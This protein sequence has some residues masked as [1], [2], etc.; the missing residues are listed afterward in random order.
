MW[1][2]GHSPITTY[3]GASLCRRHP[4]G[5]SRQQSQPRGSLRCAERAM[6]TSW[7]APCSCGVPP[8]ALP[9]RVPRCGAARAP[10]VYRLVR[11]SHAV[12]LGGTVDADGLWAAPGRPT[13]HALGQAP[14][15]RPAQGS[16][17]GLWGVSH[18]LAVGDVGMR[19]PGHA[20]PCGLRWDGTVRASCIGLGVE[21]GHGGRQ[22]ERSAARRT[23]GPAPVAEGA[24]ASACA[25]GL[26]GC[27]RSPSCGP[28]SGPRGGPEGVRRQG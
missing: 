16:P 17:A 10:G 1:Y 5:R 9:R 13:A 27:T 3:P 4:D 2:V 23:L 6:G 12:P 21:T 25:G 14:G 11:L 15:G 19:P 22:R 28:Q 7:R 26:C 20:A 18:P 24:L 8:A